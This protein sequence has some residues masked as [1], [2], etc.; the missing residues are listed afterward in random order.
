MD[1]SGYLQG[2][3]DGEI[4][5][6]ARILAVADVIEAV[7]SHCPYR[8]ALG[9]DVAC[10]EITEHSGTRYDSRVAEACV[11]LLDQTDYKLLR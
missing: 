3:K 6:E 9:L 10:G 4:L 1:G 8:P 5:A 11:Q 2:L 7:A